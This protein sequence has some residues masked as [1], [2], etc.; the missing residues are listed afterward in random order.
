MMSKHEVT[1]TAPCRRQEIGAAWATWIDTTTGLLSAP[2][3]LGVGLLL[4][5]AG[6]AGSATAADA[7]MF[8]GAG[9]GGSVVVAQGGSE[10]STT[11]APAIPGSRGNTFAPRSGQTAALTPAASGIGNSIPPLTTSPPAAF[12]S[13]VTGTPDSSPPDLSPAAF[14][15]EPPPA[16]QGGTPATPGDLSGFGTDP[17]TTGWSDPVGTLSSTPTGSGSGFRLGLGAEQPPLNRPL[18]AWE[19]GLV[20]GAWNALEASAPVLDP[21]AK[22][23]E[24]TLAFGLGVGKRVLVDTPVGIGTLGYKVLTAADPEMR[25]VWHEE[26]DVAGADAEREEW[27]RKAVDGAAWTIER[28]NRLRPG[29]QL[30]GAVQDAWSRQPVGTSAL[31]SA[32]GAAELGHAAST[33]VG[34]AVDLPGWIHGAQDLEGPQ[35]WYQF[36]QSGASL[37]LT[38]LGGAGAV[39]KLRQLGSA[40]QL[41]PGAV[42]QAPGVGPVPVSNPAAAAAEAGA[43]PRGLASLWNRPKVDQV[44]QSAAQRGAAARM[45]EATDRRFTGADLARRLRL[46]QKAAQLR[47]Q[48]PAASASS[49]PPTQGV[50]AGAGGLDA[51]DDLAALREFQLLGDVTMRPF[52]L[53]GSQALPI[54]QGGLTVGRVTSGTNSSGQVISHG[55]YSTLAP[56]GAV[57]GGTVSTSPSKLV[58]LDSTPYFNAQVNDLALRR[59]LAPGLLTGDEGHL[60]TI[61]GKG[62]IDLLQGPGNWQLVSGIR[63]GEYI[64]H[65]TAPRAIAP[66]DIVPIRAANGSIRYVRV[67]EVQVGMNRLQLPTSSD[68]FVLA[69]DITGIR[70]G[71]TG[72]VRLQP[73]GIRSGKRSLSVGHNGAVQFDGPTLLTNAEGTAVH[74]PSGTVAPQRPWMRWPWN[75]PNDR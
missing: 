1:S 30:A 53:G 20:D 74:V 54:K 6:T 19:E 2:R 72:T 16:Q 13:T 34:H 47:P 50:T 40:A 57:P 64:L 59:G 38:A 43:S 22:F 42:R 24:N 31:R 58:V 4:A 26:Y 18:S 8:T 51:L 15:S 39:S 23:A 67:S 29:Q 45:Y 9:G 65:R 25:P 62:P 41:A 35:R 46:E 63:R 70:E 49:V 17:A 21:A 61:T 14:R 56:D 52:Q 3:R 69:G 73:R 36:G 11:V 68:R 37:G 28:A 48:P 32:E 66:R 5:A 12:T 44:T 75:R 27:A 60:F 33:M 55:G 71:I 7:A 10:A